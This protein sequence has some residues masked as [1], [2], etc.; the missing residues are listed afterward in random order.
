MAGLAA[1]SAGIVAIAIAVLNPTPKDQIL[2]SALVLLV[3]TNIPA[4]SYMNNYNEI[5]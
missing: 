2:T 1:S 4:A 5:H 3:A